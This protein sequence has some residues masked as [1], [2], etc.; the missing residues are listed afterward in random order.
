MRVNDAGTNLYRIDFVNYNDPNVSPLF[1]TIN[2]VMIVLMEE[3]DPGLRFTINPGDDQF[4]PLGPGPNPV[5]YQLPTDFGDGA[6]VTATGTVHGELSE[7]S[8][9]HGGFV[10][11]TGTLRMEEPSQRFLLIVRLG[12]E[13]EYDPKILPSFDEWPVG[14]YEIGIFAGGTSSTPFLVTFFGDGRAFY[15]YRGSSC[16]VN[17]DVPFDHIEAGNPCSGL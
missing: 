14:A 1:E 6:A 11:Q 8:V 13:Y 12:V 16:D 15:P 4:L 9:R 5:T 7:E 3:A 2:G 10:H 17:L